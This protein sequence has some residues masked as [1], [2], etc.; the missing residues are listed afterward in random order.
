[1]VL[2]VRYDTNPA[3]EMQRAI[4]L[5]KRFALVHKLNIERLKIFHNHPDL[6][7][8]WSEDM[9]RFMLDNHPSTLLTS[10][11]NLPF[12]VEY[13]HTSTEE[14]LLEDSSNIILRPK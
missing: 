9:R 7:A 12:R 4:S 3:K 10:G 14:A 6:S 5:A 11:G 1:M 2:N 8:D 13:F